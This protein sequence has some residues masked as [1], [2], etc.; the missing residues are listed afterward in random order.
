MP[1]GFHP[2]WINFKPLQAG[3]STARPTSAND[4]RM[5]KTARQPRP[6]SAVQGRS[7]STVKIALSSPTSGDED[8]EDM[9]DVTPEPL[10]VQDNVTVFQ[11]INHQG[12]TLFDHPLNTPPEE[13]PPVFPTKPE[14][15]VNPNDFAAFAL[16]TKSK[17]VKEDKNAK[18]ELT[19][20]GAYRPVT[21]KE[22][23]T[24]VTP[25]ETV[26]KKPKRRPQPQVTAVQFSSTVPS[27]TKYDVDS[28]NQVED[29]DSEPETLTRA[30][31]KAIAKENMD[32]VFASEA[33]GVNAEADKD[34]LQDDLIREMRAD[35]DQMAEQIKVLE[36]N[37][38]KLKRETTKKPCC[39][40]S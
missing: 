19:N 39:A 9:E 2:T 17:K 23:D 18:P 13:E 7:K 21:P 28:D 12:R 20:F 32:G 15:E 5:R 8:T 31:K 34:A 6:S 40:V 4:V 10:N 36:K 11:Q 14:S 24:D 27:S 38:K 37:L 29:C 25:K 1:E 16:T 33:F 26:E 3:G 22:E 35:I 30:D